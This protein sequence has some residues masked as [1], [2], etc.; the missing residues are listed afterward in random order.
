MERRRADLCASYQR[1]VFDA[2]VRKTRLALERG[3]VGQG[4]QTPPD[5]SAANP[6]PVLF[7]SRASY[8]ASGAIELNAKKVGAYIKHRFT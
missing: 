4:L 1:A 2:L 5:S 8:D 7:Y 6:L 3:F